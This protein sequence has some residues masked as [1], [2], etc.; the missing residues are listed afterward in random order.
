MGFPMNLLLQGLQTPPGALVVPLLH[1]A[2]LQTSLSNWM[3]TLPLVLYS[4]VIPIIRGENFDGN[5]PLLMAAYFSTILRIVDIALMNRSALKSFTY[6]EYL[7]YFFAFKL[8][9]AIQKNGDEIGTHN[10]DKHCVPYEKLTIGYF[11]R[12]GIQFTAKYAVYVAII[13]HLRTR[14]SWGLTPTRRLQDY[15]DFSLALDIHLLGLALSLMM[16]VLTTIGGHFAALTFKTQYVPIMNAPYFATSVRNFWSDRWNLIVQRGLKRVVFDPTLVLLGHEIKK[17]KRF[18]ASHLAFAS[19]M[20]FVVSGIMH[21]W[22]IWI[23]CVQ[24]SR[25]E[26]LLYFTM[27]GFITILEVTIRKLTLRSTGVD[28]AKVIPYPIQLLYTHLVLM[29]TSPLF[30]NPYIRE[31]F[32]LKYALA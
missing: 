20:T 1:Y 16:E 13:R 8:P 14:A 6:M 19:L 9:V 27:H 24:P 17:A 2:L 25:Y 32:F 15:S 21:E 30:M 3:A 4:I 29:T 23:N 12:V 22:T 7:E 18:P 5:N 31:G 28:L 26:Q 11:F 10:M